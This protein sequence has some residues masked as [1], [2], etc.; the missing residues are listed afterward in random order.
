MIRER[1]GLRFWFHR[2]Y[3]DQTSP[4]GLISSATDVARFM[5]AYLN[6]G[7]TI[8]Q[9]ATISLMNEPLESLSTPEI[10]VRGLGWEA[11]LTADGRRYLT[12]SGGGPGFATIFRVYPEEN[13]GVVVM[14]ND[15][16][17][18]RET[19]ADALTNLNW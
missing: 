16:T 4:T 8:L 17:I 9:P 1:A 12:H 3:N 2:V 15:S 18:N 19:L 7:E 11:H 5:S 10:S 13:L 14:G 6:D